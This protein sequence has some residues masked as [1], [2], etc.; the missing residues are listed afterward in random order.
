MV[1][2]WVRAALLFHSRS[3]LNRSSRVLTASS[4]LPLACW[5]VARSNRVWRLVGVF[6]EGGAQIILGASRGGLA[7]KV[8]HG[9]GGFDLF[10]FGERAGG[11]GDQG[12][13]Q[14]KIAEREVGADQASVG[15]GVFGVFFEDGGEGFH[16]VGV[17][18]IV[19][20]G[21]GGGDGIGKAV[22]GLW[23]HRGE[24]V[25]KAFEFRRRNIALEAIDR[26]ALEEG[27]DGGDGLDAQLG[28][29]R[30]IF[31][32]V[33]LHHADAALGSGDGGLQGWAEGFAGAAPWRPEID[34]DRD[35]LRRLDDVLQEGDFRAVGDQIGGG[36]CCG[37]GCGAEHEK[38]QRFL[39]WVIYGARGVKGEGG[40]RWLRWR[41]AWRKIGGSDACSDVFWR[42]QYAW[43]AAD[44]RSGAV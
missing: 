8:E 38:P 15:D 26:L 11:G 22:V 18:A 12:F 37:G 4:T 2:S 32:D 42:Q 25:D 17:F 39:G 24:F 44:C 16:G 5:A 10:G 7:G 30:L 27:I 9:A 20:H 41:L 31:V 34:D 33:D 19:Q 6:G 21:F 13:G 14:I 40:L 36:G 1:N 35:G 3:S 29:E 43:N 23:P 28:G